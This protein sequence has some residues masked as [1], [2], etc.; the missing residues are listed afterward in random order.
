MKHIIAFAFSLILNFEIKAQ[1]QVLDSI[2]RKPIPF[3]EFFSKEGTLL[4]ICN[5]DGYI[6]KELI[7][8]SNNLSITINQPGYQKKNILVQNLPNNNDILLLKPTKLTQQSLL[9]PEIV[10]ESRIPKFLR[11]K[12][13]FRSI[14]FNNQQ[15]Q[16]YMDGI[17]EYY[18]ATTSMANKNSI[19]E[20][21]SFREKQIPI[22]KEKGLIQLDFN[23]VG[24]PYLEDFLIAKNLEKKYTISRNTNFSNLEKD[25]ISVGII[26]LDSNKTSLDLAIYSEKNI[27]TMRMFGVES[28]LTKYFISASYST[29]KSN[30]ELKD[31]NWFKEIREYKIKSKKYSDESIFN[32]IHEVFVLEKDFVNDKAK[33]TNSFYT[34]QY[35]NKYESKFWEL[36]NIPPISEEVQKF[37]DSKMIELK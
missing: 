37:I 8:N 13:F 20:S 28:N 9:L 25:T 12:A 23:L 18:I 15:P 3:V 33:S 19:L 14:Q 5:F 21:R 29:T 16:Y 10:V 32:T 34:F 6:M 30:F 36:Q 26:K 27:K 4:G 24:V 1:I 31:L 11:I 7:S 35:K 17:V 2:S 22:L